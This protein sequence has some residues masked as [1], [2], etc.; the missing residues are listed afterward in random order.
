VATFTKLTTLSLL[1]LCKLSFLVASLKMSSLPT[2]A[3]KSPYQNFHMVCREYLILFQDTLY[4]SHF[5]VKYT[6]FKF[7]N[8]FILQTAFRLQ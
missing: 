3:V 6:S 5:I 7:A 2:L 1:I 4:L 8:N